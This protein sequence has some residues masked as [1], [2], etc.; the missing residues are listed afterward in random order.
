MNKLMTLE[1]FVECVAAMRNAQRQ[2]FKT[3]S[4]DWLEKS[5]ELER[6]IDRMIADFRDP[7]GDLFK[8]VR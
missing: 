8:G 2:Y 6:N 1:N 4:S 7:Q 5:K 3:R